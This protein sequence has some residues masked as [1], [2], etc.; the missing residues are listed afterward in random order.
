MILSEILYCNGQ[1]T[2]NVRTFWQFR[3]ML[4]L[5]HI[6]FSRSVKIKNPKRRFLP[7]FLGLGADICER[8]LTTRKNM[9][10]KDDLSDKAL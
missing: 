1:F 8:S 9:L 4:E 2:Y 7:M 6:I 5:L 3:T 10:L